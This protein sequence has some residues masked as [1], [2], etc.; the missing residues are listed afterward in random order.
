MDVYMSTYMLSNISM[1]KI[2]SDNL[3]MDKGCI[4]QKLVRI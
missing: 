3:C 4:S 2:G 1:L